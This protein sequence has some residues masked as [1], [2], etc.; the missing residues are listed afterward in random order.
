MPGPLCTIGIVAEEWKNQMRYLLSLLRKF[1][2]VERM[3]RRRTISFRKYQVAP[4][5]GARAVQRRLLV[6]LFG[7][8]RTSSAILEPST[9]S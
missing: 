4:R 3:V 7:G 9:E 8:E 2:W 6:R 1:G 5:Q